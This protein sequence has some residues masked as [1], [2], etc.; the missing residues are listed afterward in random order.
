MLDDVLESGFH[1]AG[2]L[3]MFPPTDQ[4]SPPV[5]VMTDARKRWL[6]PKDVVSVETVAVQPCQ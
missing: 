1:L 3:G 2:S 6:H 4:G 5:S